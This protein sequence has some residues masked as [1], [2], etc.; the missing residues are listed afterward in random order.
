MSRGN[1][2]VSQGW[3]MTRE[4]RALRPCR[5]HIGYIRLPGRGLVYT[6]TNLHARINRRAGWWA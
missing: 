2:W 6:S 1:K 3:Y 4:Y 5:P